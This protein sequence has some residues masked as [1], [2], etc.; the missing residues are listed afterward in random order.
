MRKRIFIAVLLLLVALL[1]AGGI[2]LAKYITILHDEPSTFT[3]SPF[4]FRSN[5]LTD[6]AVDDLAPITV[7]GGVTTVVL[8]N[9]ADNSTH[10]EQTIK[11]TVNYY[12]LVNDE[13]EPMSALSVGG[14]LTGNVH[15]SVTIT[16]T[17]LYGD[18]VGDEPPT[19]YD[20]VLV[21]AV[22]SEP[23]QKTLRAW[24]HFEYTEFA[25]AH[26]FDFDMAMVTC[27][28]TTNDD[29]GVF[30]ISYNEYLLPDNADP[31]GIL[32]EAQAGASF[33]IPTLTAR[34]TYRLYFFV[35]PERLAELAELLE[36]M[37]PEEQLAFLVGSVTC[38]KQ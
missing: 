24:L 26:D 14:E 27:K 10:T 5:V 34:T 1:I 35:K 3:V 12:A 11:Y 7:Q 31:N 4:Y 18:A 29:A 37:P 21:V 33:V 22:A 25:V 28:I 13:W 32:T 2:T 15:S 36:A 20:D 17:P 9:S 6:T 30:K 16:A 23:Y 19:R 38:E 8:A